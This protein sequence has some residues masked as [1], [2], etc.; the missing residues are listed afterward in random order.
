MDSTAP[1]TQP[2]HLDKLP[3]ELLLDI[4]QHT[5]ADDDDGSAERRRRLLRLG[6]C[7]KRIA[8]LAQRVLWRHVSLSSERLGWGSQDPLR[9]VVIACADL[10]WTAGAVKRLDIEHFTRGEPLHLDLFAMA[11]P[12]VQHLDL[13]N[14]GM[15]DLTHTAF[16]HGASLCSCSKARCST[17]SSAD[18][19][20]SQSCAPSSS[21]ASSPSSR[22]AKRPS[23][24]PSSSRSTSVL[25]T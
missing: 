6:R 18:A 9:R 3:N 14:I 15:F 24:S 17:R 22:R 10:E 12:A 23:S 7:S 16:F 19:T 2:C 5:V 25:S 21:T 11:L 13:R 20:F 8:G 1:A 4:I